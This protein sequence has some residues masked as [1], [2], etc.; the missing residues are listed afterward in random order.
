MLQWVKDLI[1]LRRSTVDLNDG[2]FGHLHVS[3]TADGKGLI[4]QRGTVRVLMYLGDNVLE[5]PLQGGEQLRLAS[6]SNIR[7][8]N[9]EITLPKM[10]LAILV[11]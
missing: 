2:D 11:R 4:M 1:H 10:S 8:D 7:I 5:C 9:S 6:T 3:C